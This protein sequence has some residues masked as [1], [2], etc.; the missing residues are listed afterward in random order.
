M[1]ASRAP[2][3]GLDLEN[4]RYHVLRLLGEGG[5]ASIFE[6]HD[7]QKNRTVVLKVPKPALLADA[8]F[9]HR[10]ARE[11]RTLVE[12]KH[13]SVVAVFGFGRHDGV[14]FA[15]L[16]HLDGGTLADQPKP[17]DPK[18]LG[19][20]L[21]D[22]AAALDHIHQAGYVHRD[23]K[24]NNILFDER[25]R[26]RLADFGIIKS[27]N[28]KANQQ[29]QALTESGIT[30][31]TPEYMAPELA[32]GHLFDGKADQYA[33]AVTV[34]ERLSG[35]RPIEGG[36]GPVILVK[37]I[38]EKPKP[39]NEVATVSAAMAMAVGRGLAK[40]P[41]ARYANC[42]EFARAVMNPER[43]TPSGTVVP[44]STAVPAP[45]RMPTAF[46]PAPVRPSWLLPAAVG[47]GML[48]ALLLAF[49]AWSLL[50]PT[51]AANVAVIEKLAIDERPTPAVPPFRFVPPNR[52]KAVAGKMGTVTVNVQRGNGWTGPI[53]IMLKS[54][55]P[56]VIPEGSTIIANDVVAATL[57]FQVKPTVK[58]AV[59]AIQGSAGDYTQEI[60]VPLEIVVPQYTVAPLTAVPLGANEETIVVVKVNRDGWTEEI[61]MTVETPFGIVA[62]PPVLTIPAEANEISFRLRP[63]GRANS[64]PVR[65]LDF[66]GGQEKSKFSITLADAAKEKT[67]AR[68]KV[69]PPGDLIGRMTSD[70][71]ILQM[72]PR[73]PGTILAWDQAHLSIWEATAPQRRFLRLVDGMPT[74]GTTS[75]DGKQILTA[76][77]SKIYVHDPQGKEVSSGA[78]KYRILGMYYDVTPN[79]MLPYFW[80]PS[81]LCNLRGTLVQ[82]GNPSGSAIRYGTAGSVNKVSLQDGKLKLTGKR[83]TTIAP[84]A[85]VDFGISHDG[86]WLVV[87]AGGRAMLYDIDAADPAAP[88]WEKEIPG[89]TAVAVAPDGKSVAIGLGSELRLIPAQL[90]E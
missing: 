88:C 42:F 78:N 35:R 4:Q 1:T 43:A 70:I 31:G 30:V 87:A 45:R 90:K 28:E 63:M 26:A 76:T 75:P 19:A 18:A 39:L 72:S 64:G 14:P 51:G 38:R 5:M 11:I 59:I 65:L 83:T 36:T 68:N 66:P 79:A 52:I 21:P 50:K 8:E 33:L 61:V 46:E 49:L 84:A 82:P 27:I 71:G 57:S 67:T 53:T 34:Y 16:E 32:K 15:V 77:K 3:V 89:L 85:I 40:D 20:W 24:P 74:C 23:V 22:I 80:T 2:W 7:R 54:R 47:G 41:K 9:V 58:S 13:P 10:F 29:T 17:C 69:Q 56:G 48:A 55:Q 86:R 25:G 73:E 12:L 81:G 60:E 6:A 37:Q 62:N 44:I